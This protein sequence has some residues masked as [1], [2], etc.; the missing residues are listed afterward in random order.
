[1]NKSE[2]VIGLAS[3]LKGIGWTG[4]ALGIARVP[5]SSLLYV[6]SHGFPYSRPIRAIRNTPKWPQVVF[7]A[8]ML[9]AAPVRYLFLILLILQL[10]NV[11]AGKVFNISA[12]IIGTFVVIGSIGLAA[13]PYSLDLPLHKKSALLHLRGPSFCKR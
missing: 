5:F 12:L 1:M 8:G 6:Q 11:G 4:V 9:I 2:P 10:R 13:I 7:N 3:A